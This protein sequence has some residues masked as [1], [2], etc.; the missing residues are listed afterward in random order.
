M[1]LNL[2]IDK[3][4]AIFY[5]L[6]LAALTKLAIAVFNTNTFDVFW[7]RTWVLDIQ[8]GLFTIYSRAGDIS[9]D[10]PPLFIVLLYPI[11]LL[12]KLV[13]PG[14][15]E[16]TDMLFM[17]LIPIT[18]D[19][20]SGLLIY[21]IGKDIK[22]EN[23]GIIAAT[24]WLLNPAVFFN[25]TIWGQT[26]TLLAFLIITTFFLLFKEKIIGATVVYACACMI[27]FQ[28]AFL[29][30]IF[31]FGL[32]YGLKK[33]SVK[34]IILCFVSALL[35]VAA[36]FVPF[37]IGAENPWL[38]FDVYFGPM[39]SYPYC[40]VNAANLYAV[41]GL[42]WVDNTTD[43][44]FGL[45]YN[46]V[47]Y[48]LVGLGVA[49]TIY[50]L[51]IGKKKSLIISSAFLMQHI[52]MF[53]TDMHERYQFV[54]LPLLLMAWIIYK[55]SRFFKLFIGY[56]VVIL[57]NEWFVLANFTKTKMPLIDY[58]DVLLAVLGVVNILLYILTLYEFIK[59]T[60]NNEKAV[61]N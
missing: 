2:K 52:F 41:L 37:S 31:L 28:C 10:Y 32:I 8:K 46:V 24:V 51:I 29:A 27:K 39:G 18:F 33:R 57:L 49:F 13:A 36:V 50:C 5:I 55:N 47:G 61:E 6:I 58:F 35:T 56:S 15:F 48:I 34:Y 54:I 42:N 38:I 1:Q 44:I 45:N 43:F 4:K 21:Y 20:L 26:D 23:A 53:M 30:P 3:R 16:I 22:D 7:Y 60:F 9:L 17:K 59:F 12:Y 25:S 11:S 14:S 19:L 40:T